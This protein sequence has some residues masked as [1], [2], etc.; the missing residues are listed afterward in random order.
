MEPIRPVYAA[1]WSRRLPI[2]TVILP[3]DRALEAL[4]LAMADG[5]RSSSTWFTDGSLLE[6]RAGGAAV[7]VERGTERERILVPLGEGQVCGGEMEGLVRATERAIEN[8]HDNIMCVADSQAA[9][10]GILSTAPRSGQYRAIRYDTI[11]R[12]ALVYNMRGTSF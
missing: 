2:T 11:V 12:H 7:R 4:R 10:R 9:L 6:G 8:G 5:R 1:P 3:K